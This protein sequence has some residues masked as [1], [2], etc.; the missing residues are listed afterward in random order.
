MTAVNNASRESP[1]AV[2]PNT[3]TASVSP[4][5][6]REAMGHFATG[7]TVITSVDADGEPVGTTAN[8]VTSLS[9]EPPLVLVCFDLNS[10]TLD[11]IRQHGAFA[12]NVLGQRQHHLS[13][14]FAKRGLSAAWDG[15]I[16]HRGPTGSPRLA[17]V[18][19][20]IECTVEHAFPGGDHEI[21]I[22][23][24][25]HVETNGEGATPLLFWRGKYAAI[26]G[27]LSA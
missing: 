13:A 24:V 22:G 18:I 27:Q 14:N 20:I 21:V 23:R 4:A 16:H 19:A 1:D 7:V 6:L 10:S 12:V 3:G 11:A 26:D 8:A 5:E 2:L 9:L 17:D 25:R 15:V